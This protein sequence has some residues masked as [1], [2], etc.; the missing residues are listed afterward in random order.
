MAEVGGWQIADVK[1]KDDRFVSVMDEMKGNTQGQ[2][3]TYVDFSAA[4]VINPRERWIALEPFIVALKDYS[5]LRLAVAVEGEAR[6]DGPGD[7]ADNKVQ[8]EYNRQQNTTAYDITVKDP[9]LASTGVPA[10]PTPSRAQARAPMSRG[11]SVALTLLI[12][13]LAM[14]AT[15]GLALTLWWKGLWPGSAKNSSG[16]RHTPRPQEKSQ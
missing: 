4:G 13:G 1:I 3:Q 7:Y 2:M 15:A 11:R 5:P 14:T 10:H 12:G 9:N 8:I 6:V 16:K